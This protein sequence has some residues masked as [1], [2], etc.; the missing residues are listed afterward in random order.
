MCAAPIIGQKLNGRSTLFVGPIAAASALYA[1]KR[2]S[3]LSEK[4][5]DDYFQVLQAEEEKAEAAKAAKE[6]AKAAKE[7]KKNVTL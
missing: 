4:E 1:G 7:A 3:G 6:A 5:R 2:Y